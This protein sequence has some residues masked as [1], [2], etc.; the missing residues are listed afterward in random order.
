MKKS[1][2]S[3]SKGEVGVA[4]LKASTIVQSRANRVLRMATKLIPE[5]SMMDE[6]NLAHD[7][8]RQMD[9]IVRAR[10]YEE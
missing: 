9:K 7:E 5:R 10:M 4:W 8:S 2:S 1:P 3:N 6:E